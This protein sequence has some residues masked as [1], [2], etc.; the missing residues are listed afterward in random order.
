MLSIAAATINSLCVLKVPIIKTYL[1]YEKP[2]DMTKL[3][4]TF[5]YNIS[6]QKE[7]SSI[8]FDAKALG[9]PL[10]KQ[11][12]CEGPDREAPFRDFF[13]N[14]NPSDRLISAL[15]QCVMKNLAEGVVS[16]DLV[17]NKRNI[18]RRMLQRRLSDSGTNFLNVMQ[19][20]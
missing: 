2:R 9:Y 11:D 20:V 19:Q 5:G 13:N 4:T 17:T 8:F 18:S 16:I 6:F 15:K 12:Y 7:Q 3:E 1:T 14:R 10:I